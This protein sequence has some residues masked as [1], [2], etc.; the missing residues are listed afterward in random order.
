[1]QEEMEFPQKLHWVEIEAI[2]PQECRSAYQGEGSLFKV[3][4]TEICAMQPGKRKELM[5]WRQ[6]RSAGRSS[7]RRRTARPGRHRQL[8]RMVRA[9]NVSRGLCPRVLVQGRAT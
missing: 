7:R 8:G 1:M 6:R 5:L 2:E 9:R 3:E 4:E